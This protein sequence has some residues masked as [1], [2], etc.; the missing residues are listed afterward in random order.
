V[1]SKNYILLAGKSTWSLNIVLLLASFIKGI[2]DSI[3]GREN[4]EAF[5]FGVI[6]KYLE[7]GTALRSSSCVIHG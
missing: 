4:L 3:L 7:D 1:H 2:E 6:Y 5:L